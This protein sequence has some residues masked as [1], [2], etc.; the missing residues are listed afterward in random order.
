M[1]RMRVYLVLLLL[2]GV[3]VGC[4][5]CGEQ[6]SPYEHLET[7]AT[8]YPMPA[9]RYYDSTAEEHQNTYLDPAVFTLL[10]GRDT[11]GDDREDI[12][13]FALFL[14]TSST[15]VYEMGIFECYDRDGANEVLGLIET[16][17]SL[18][19]S[20]HTGADLTALADARLALFGKTVVY[21]VLPDNPKAIRVLERM[22]K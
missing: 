6:V 8:L 4:V 16:R 2:F 18:I 9:G 19:A 3:I 22:M 15:H 20:S 17:L 5:G 1:K 10:Y 21:V 14:G 12:R 11:T 7:F 13:R